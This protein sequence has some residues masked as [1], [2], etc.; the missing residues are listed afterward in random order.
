M[1][2]DGPPLEDAPGEDAPAELVEWMERFGVFQGGVDPEAL[3]EAAIRALEEA[4]RRTGGNREAAFALLAADG[5]ITRAVGELAKAE[6]PEA[7]LLA[8]ISRVAAGS[9]EGPQ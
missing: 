6:D 4:T 5:L 9:G 1:S 8:L 2:P 3:A 7:D